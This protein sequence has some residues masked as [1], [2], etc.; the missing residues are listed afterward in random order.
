VISGKLVDMLLLDVV[1]HDLGVEAENGEIEW[2]IRKNTAIPTKK[3]D[4]FHTCIDLQTEAVLHIV[5]GDA[6]K[7]EGRLS[8]SR[9]LF[10]SITK[11]PAGE[12]EI[13][14]CFD[15]NANHTLDVYVR[16]KSSQRDITFNLAKPKFDLAEGHPSCGPI[17]KKEVVETPVQVSDAE[18]PKER[19]DKSDPEKPAFLRKVMD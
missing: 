9:F 11:K 18:P 10:D 5:E 15:I 16:D 12:A 2:M 7:P 1:S 8:L 13:E 4:I 19:I 3:C 14:I 17:R 6:G